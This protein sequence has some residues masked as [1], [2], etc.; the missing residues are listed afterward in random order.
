MDAGSEGV[1]DIVVVGV[2]GQGILTATDVIA[3][4]FLTAGFDVKKSEVHGMAQRGGSV[5]SHVRRHPEEVHSPLVCPGGA[6]AV[7]AFEQMEALRFARMVRDGGVIIY[8]TQRIPTVSMS[9]GEAEYPE[10]IE[11]RLGR[12]TPHII[13]IHAL[14]VARELGNPRVTNTILV[15]ALSGLTEVP[16]A[17]WNDALLD[18]IPAR[19]TEVNLQALSRGR[20]LVQ[21]YRQGR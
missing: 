8:S 17:V 1:N 15:G 16:E 13:P 20:C 14:D 4:A 3:N 19:F 6:D 7:V 18:R 10:D 12:Y 2:G 11:R 5:E 9:M 21:Q